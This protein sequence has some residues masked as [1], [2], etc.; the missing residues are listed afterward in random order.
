MKQLSLVEMQAII[1]MF[2]YVSDILVRSC[3]EGRM[4]SA[5]A[6]TQNFPSC[7]QVIVGDFCFFGGD[8]KSPEARNLVSHIPED[9]AKRL[10]FM[11]PENKDWGRLIEE[12]Y[13]GRCEK[14]TR[15]AMKSNPSF[16]RHHL[17]SIASDL[18]EDYTMAKINVQ[19]Y[20][21][22]MKEDWCRDF[23]GNFDN[24]DD[25]LQNGLGVVILHGDKVI[26]GASS[27]T[28]CNG[29]IE[30][31]VATHSDYRRQGLATICSAQLIL[32]CLKRGLIPNW[33][34]ANLISVKTARRLGYKLDYSYD[35]YEISCLK[36]RN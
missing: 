29:A 35:T 15:Y 21:Q 19:L 9:Y 6:D 30:I 36:N 1:P 22:I 23:C 27:Y 28:V 18:P 31:E 24:A 16:E 26:A 10:M 2:S 13:A 5:W 12:T 20:H 17:F 8:A 32:E 33:D 34:A 3:V 11:V 25:F 4:G 7:A 14:T